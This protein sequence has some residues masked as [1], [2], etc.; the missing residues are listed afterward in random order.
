[1]CP[2][3][4][5][6]LVVRLIWHSRQQLSTLLRPSTCHP[7][8]SPHSPSK[9][10]T[11]TCPPTNPHREVPSYPTPASTHAPASSPLQ[12]GEHLLRS[13]LLLLPELDLYLAKAITGPRYTPPGEFV[14][15]LLQT[16][17]LGGEAAAC[18]PA[19]DLPNAT[20][21]LAQ[22]AT[23]VSGGSAVLQLLEDAR[24]LARCTGVC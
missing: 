15:H 7:S 13:R 16:A 4:L 8:P 6:K 21:A 23:R 14:V 10:G 19:S 18:N 5:E 20:E 12:V 22:L 9:N 17:I 1:M 3:V 2:C 24:R 11:C